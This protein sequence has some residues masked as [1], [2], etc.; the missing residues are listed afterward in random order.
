MA[1]GVHVTSEIG[2]LRRVC[3]HRPGGELLNLPPAELGRLLFEDIPLL[4]AAR[5]EH[6]AFA[7]ALRDRGVEVVYLEDLVAEVFDAVPGARAAFQE[8][9]LVEA[10]IEGTLVADAV[11]ERLDAIADNRAFVLKTMAGI[12]KDEVSIA[13]ASASTLDAL[14]RT[15]SDSALIVDPM[16]NLYFTRDP[17]A[18]IGEGVACMR[19]FSATR[20]RETIYG[21]YVLS[22][23]PRYRSAPR[24]YRRDASFHIE[25]GDVLVLDARTVAVGVSQRTQAAAIDVLAQHLFWREPSP[26]ER[27]L[28]FVIPAR[29]A[30]MH[31]DTVFTQVDADAFTVY[32]AVMRTLEVFELTRGAAPSEVRIRRIEDTLEHV[33]AR[34]CGLD[35]VRLIPCGGGDA[36]A[37]ARE[38]WSDGSNTLAIAPGEL[39][40]YQRNALTNEALAKAGMELTVIPSAELSRGRGGPRCM[41]MPLVRDDL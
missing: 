31:L 22:Y 30:F 14:V 28:A 41:S 38:Q 1:Q 13:H 36:I 20:N 11:R 37:A 32:P 9:Y 5:A 18:V 2:R 33:L 3:L 26:I 21:D 8:R 17:M 12:R 15:D 29:R 35:A 34:A 39:V 25:G 7:G 16:P 24:Y 40:V 27:V 4:E 10:G 23:H 19:M 6:D